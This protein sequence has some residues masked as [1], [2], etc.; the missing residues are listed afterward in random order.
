MF[1]FVGILQR[2]SAPAVGEVKGLQ[3]ITSQ[4]QEK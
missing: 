1:W 2:I 3:F 4:I